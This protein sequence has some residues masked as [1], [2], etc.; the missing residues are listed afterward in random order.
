ML[1]T[2]HKTNPQV[3]MASFFYVGGYTKTQSQLQCFC[4]QQVSITIRICAVGV[5]RVLTLE[6]TVFQLI[7]SVG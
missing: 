1:L 6:S 4:L 2:H 5:Q 3:I 7:F